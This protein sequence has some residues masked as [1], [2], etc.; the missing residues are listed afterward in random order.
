MY[1]GDFPIE[2][3]FDK[4]FD[5]TVGGVP[6]ALAG[7]PALVAY[8]DNSTTEITAGITLTEPSFDGR[9]GLCNVRVVLTAANGYATGTN[10]DLVY[11]SG[12]LG[13]QTVVGRTVI[14]FSIGK[15]S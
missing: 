15:R 7:S 12:T 13:G 11:S 5:T 8:V 1:I 2:A 10:V 4:K 9:V 6:T 14:S 3:T